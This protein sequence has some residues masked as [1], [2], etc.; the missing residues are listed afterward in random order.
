MWPTSSPSQAG[1]HPDE[2]QRWSQPNAKIP[3][4]ASVED[5]AHEEI[6]TR[7]TLVLLARDEMGRSPA[8]LSEDALVSVFQAHGRFLLPLPSSSFVSATRPIKDTM[9]AALPALYQPS[10]HSTHNK[11]QPKLATPDF[12]RLTSPDAPPLLQPPCHVRSMRRT[13]RSRLLRVISVPEAPRHRQCRFDCSLSVS[14]VRP[15]A[16]CVLDLLSS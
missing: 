16:D 6:E 2:L 12:S 14:L 5:R 1:T 9:P 11:P 8:N 15:W 4:Q 13:L 7:E 10:P 3:H